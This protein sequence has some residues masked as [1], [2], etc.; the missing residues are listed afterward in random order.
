MVQPQESFVIYADTTV[1]F[2]FNI[3]DPEGEISSWVWYNF[4]QIGE[5]IWS[6]QKTTN[7][8]S[9]TINSSHEFKI[10][11]VGGLAPY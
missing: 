7:E 6:A 5:V 9:F 11:D 4:N 3:S 1:L 2:E 10:G 8:S